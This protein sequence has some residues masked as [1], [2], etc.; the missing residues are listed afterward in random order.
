[1][2]RILQAAGT[3]AGFDSRSIVFNVMV[4]EGVILTIDDGCSEQ[5]PDKKKHV[6]KEHDKPPH[7]VDDKASSLKGLGGFHGSVIVGTDRIY[8]NAVHGSEGLIAPPH[9][10]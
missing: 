3:L 5:A 8:Y 2:V 1:M 6:K 7:A 4:P 10:S 9:H